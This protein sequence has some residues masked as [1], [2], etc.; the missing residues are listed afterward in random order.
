MEALTRIVIADD[1]PA[2]C[3]G[4]RNMLTEDEGFTVVGEA[5][6]GDE[7]IAET[8][9]LKPDI[10]LLD[11]AMPRLP[12]LEAMRAIMKSSPNA[13]I[14]LL[15]GAITSEQIVE[16]LHMG[17]RGIVLKDA[18][19][20]DVKTA[21]H[22]VISGDYW[23]GGKRVVDLACTLYELMQQSLP[24]LQR[25]YGLTPREMEVLGC[26]VE[27][28]TNRDIARKLAVSEETVKRHLANIFDKTGIST[29]LELALFGISHHVTWPP[30]A[31]DST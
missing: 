28:G 24:P 6:D 8:L 25:Q 14:I 23:I 15:T 7:A 16:A 1:H 31:D 12:G 22:T 10:L 11:V 9:E 18:L 21:I 26:I 3:V 20:E 29:R 5:S 4:V 2:V 27:G 19:A 30:L 13:R 17:A